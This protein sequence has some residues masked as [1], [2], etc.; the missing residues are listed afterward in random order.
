M[1]PWSLDLSSLG[2]VL[3]FGSCVP[4]AGVLVQPAHT[5]Q[6]CND[7]G[8]NVRAGSPKAAGTTIGWPSGSRGEGVRRLPRYRLSCSTGLWLSPTGVSVLLP[9]LRKHGHRT[10]AHRAGRRL[11]L[12]LPRGVPSIQRW[13]KLRE[14]PTSKLKTSGSHM[15]TNRID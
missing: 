14:V 8:Q 12:T 2:V 4:G 6:A 13:Y 9:Q 7:L 11:S 5:M 3:Y 1:A 15:P 10:L